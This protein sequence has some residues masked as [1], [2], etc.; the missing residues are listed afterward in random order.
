MV[1]ICD[2]LCKDIVQSSKKFDALYA[3]L[4]YK[5]DAYNLAKKQ[6]QQ[7]IVTDCVII[8]STVCKVFIVISFSNEAAEPDNVYSLFQ[9]S[10][11]N[12]KTF[13]RLLTIMVPLPNYQ[14]RFEYL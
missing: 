13:A 10:K 11:L 14:L 5:N 8:S 4:L 12:C 7:N 2:I 1:D 3:E 6:Q 9:H